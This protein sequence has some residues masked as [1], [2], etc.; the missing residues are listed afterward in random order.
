MTAPEIVV[1]AIP[2]ARPISEP[3]SG[4]GEAEVLSSVTVNLGRIEGGVSPNLVPASAHVAADIRIPVGVSCTEVEASLRE[5][6][7]GIDGI[8]LTIARRFEPQ[9]TDPDAELSGPRWK[10]RRMC[11]M[12]R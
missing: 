6:L 3:L 7:P 11:C 9:F 4:N 2:A 10:R 1:Q 8:R 5:A 12:K